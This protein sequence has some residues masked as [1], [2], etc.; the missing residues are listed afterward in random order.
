MRRI[1]EFLN[2]IICGNCLEVMKEMPSESVDLVMFSPPYWGLRDY[3]EEAIAVWGGDPNCEHEWIETAENLEGYTS[4]RRWQHGINREENPECWSREIKKYGFCVKCGAWRGQLGLEPHPQMYIDHLVMICREIKR[5][6][7]KSG[8]MYINLGDTYY[9]GGGTQGRPKERI[10]LERTKVEAGA[11]PPPE[12]WKIRGSFRSNWLQPKQKLLIP[13]R[14][15]IALQEDG[16]IIRNDIIWHKPNAMPSSVKDRLNVTHEYIFHCVKSRKYYYNLDAIREPHSIS[17]FK[18][19]FQR[20]VFEQKGGEKQIL[21]RGE[22]KSP[23]D[24]GSRCADMVKSIAEKYVQI[25]IDDL[26]DFCLKEYERRIKKRTPYKHKDSPLIPNSFKSA[27]EWNRGTRE[28]MNEIIDSLNIPENIKSKLR[29]WWHDRQGHP[30]GKNLGDIIFPHGSPSRRNRDYKNLEKFVQQQRQWY[31]GK[32]E[33]NPKG[34]NPG[35]VFQSKKKPYIGNNPHRMRLQKDKYLALDPSRPMDLSH[36]LGKNPGSFW[37][38]STKPFPEAHF[39][40]YPLSLCVRPILSSCPPDGIILDPFVGSGTTCLAAELINRKLWDE[41][42]YTPNETAK[43][44]NWNLKWIGIEINPKYV[45]IA[46]RRLKPYIS[47]K[48]LIGM[49]ES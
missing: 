26:K 4:K 45:E 38:I 44:I 14:V 28:T 20:N 1:E 12:Y 29:A 37:S 34:K 18:R 40:V 35:D 33:N 27:S 15:A 5:I 36:P 24:R 2:R 48:T 47:Q 22:K 25:D 10:D 7:K 19:I 6:L 49:L 41:L 46:K 31:S 23:R 39:A 8:S 30:K 3:G 13:F 9:G 21:L 16:W 42:D 17:T 32:H 43:K 11:Y